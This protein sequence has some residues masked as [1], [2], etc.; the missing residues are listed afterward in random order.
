MPFAICHGSPSGI[1][2]SRGTW[3]PVTEP[4]SKGARSQELK[5]RGKVNHDLTRSPVVVC[6]LFPPL[7]TISPLSTLSF[8]LCNRFFFLPRHRRVSF[9]LCLLSNERRKCVRTAITKKLRAVRNLR[10]HRISTPASTPRTLI[11]S[12]PVPKFVDI[13]TSTRILL[14]FCRRRAIDQLR[15]SL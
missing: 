8:R 4:A 6:L 15:N 5:R 3:L 12:Y 10:R 1:D 11:P 13:C 9:T 14:L 2:F 7:S